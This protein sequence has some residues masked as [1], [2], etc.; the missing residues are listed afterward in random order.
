MH[1]IGVFSWPDGRKYIGFYEQEK[2]SGFG[3]FMWAK[4]KCKIYLGFWNKS[5]QNS[6]AKIITRR[7]ERYS[8]WKDGNKLSDYL[9]SESFFCDLSTSYPQFVNI[10]KLSFEKLVEFSSF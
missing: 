7:Q 5:K 8:Y 10:F 2:L 4:P 3:M 1:G 9:S 6:F